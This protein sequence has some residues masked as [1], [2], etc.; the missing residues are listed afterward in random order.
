MSN[1]AYVSDGLIAALGALIGLTAAV[2]SHCNHDGCLARPDDPAPRLALSAGPVVFRGDITG[3]ELYLRRDAGRQYGP[4]R[5]VYGASISDAGEAWLG[6]GFTYLVQPREW[7]VYAEFHLMPGLY[8]SGGGADLGGPIEFRSG[9][10]LGYETSRGLRIG[11]GVDHR[12][13]AGLYDFNPGLETVHLRVSWP[14]GR[15]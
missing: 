15:R 10:E 8:A 9:L 5:P 6:A 4:L 13:N 3:T 1:L 7:P 14:L 2:G 12:S 11:L